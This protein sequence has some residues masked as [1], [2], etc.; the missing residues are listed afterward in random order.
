M[1]EKEEILP[2]LCGGRPISF[3]TVSRSKY[4]F[5]HMPWEHFNILTTGSTTLP[6]HEN[7]ESDF[8]CLMN[9]NYAM[10]LLQYVLIYLYNSV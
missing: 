3:V 8:N 4:F 6:R 7:K 1:R 5:M 10:I 2:Y 9:I